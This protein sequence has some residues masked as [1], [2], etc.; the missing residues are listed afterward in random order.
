MSCIVMKVTGK[1]SILLNFGLLGG[2]ICLLVEGN[3]LVAPPVP[4]AQAR[5]SAVSPAPVAQ[6]EPVKPAPFRWNQLDA[7]DYHVYVKN[8]RSIG[9]PEPTVRA[10]VTADVDSVYQIM[11]NQMEQK[12]SAEEN[13]SWSNQLAVAS[14]E[15]SLK[16]ELQRIPEEEAGKIADLLGLKPAAAVAPATPEIPLVE[17]LVLADVDLSTLNLDADQKEIVAGLRQN[18][19]QE[20][21]DTNQASSDPAFNARWRGAQSKSDNLLMAFLGY[22]IYNQYQMKA[23][24]TLVENH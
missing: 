23:S 9:C 2:L 5:V 15:P 8:L 13:G 10:I 6:A 11:A 7:K 20:V 18:F 14:S 1:I 22:Q 3:P 24:E 4:P 21:G 19:L 17:P 12:L 16:E